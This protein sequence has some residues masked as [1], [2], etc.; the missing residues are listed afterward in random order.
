[1]RRYVRDAGDLLAELNVLTRC[2]STTRDPRKAALLS[3]RMDELE[4]RITELA[5]EE[6]LRAIRPELDG[7][8]V[9]THLGI[10]PG[11]LVGEALAHL[12]EIRLDE[13]EIG[14]DEAVARLDQW[15]KQ[16]SP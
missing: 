1:V 3:R 12:L 5:A 13:G 2:D 9:M 11:P 6:E 10:G 14:H 16:R 7:N 15:W 4:A 8:Q